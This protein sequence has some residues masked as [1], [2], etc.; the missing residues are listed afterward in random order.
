[1]N[2]CPICNQKIESQFCGMTG[3]IVSCENFCFD[4]LENYYPHCP[5][6][7]V[8]RLSIPYM[9]GEQYMRCDNQNCRFEIK[10]IS[11]FKL[12]KDGTID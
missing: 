11:I 12:L 1:M 10:A 4:H 7:K 6:C 9:H 3:N 2:K 8:G 5:I